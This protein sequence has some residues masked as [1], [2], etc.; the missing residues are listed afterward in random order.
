[1]HVEPT[2]GNDHV[3]MVSFPSPLAKDGGD[4]ST[5]RMRWFAAKTDKGEI[6]EAPAVLVVHS[7]HPKMIIGCAIV[8]GFAAR[9]L[10]AFVIEM[11]GYVDRHVI[12][13]ASAMVAMERSAQTIAEVRR[14][15]TPSRHYPRSKGSALR[16]KAQAS[17]VSSPPS[18]HPWTM[19]SIRSS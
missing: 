10:H 1:M 11:P 8:R 6:I 15:A 13:R 2:G 9:G 4:L 17:A 7:V 12:G 19:R 3:A 14:R 16:C 5:V 18:P